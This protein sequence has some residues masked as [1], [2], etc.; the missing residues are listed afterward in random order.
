[1]EDT[2]LPKARR[3]EGSA[4]NAFMEDK[5]SK[6]FYGFQGLVL[7]KIP[8][9]EAVRCSQLSKNWR[10]A[11]THISKLMLSPS[12][13]LGGLDGIDIISGILRLHSSHVE[14]FYLFHD[15]LWD[16]TAEKVSTWV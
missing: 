6:L 12:D 7:S 4:V 14:S 5:L 10:Y 15:G 13:L 16:F 1:M 2:H 9:R 8:M 11:Y 3:P